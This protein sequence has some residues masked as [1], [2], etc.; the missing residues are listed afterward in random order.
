YSIGNGLVGDLN[1]TGPG[2]EPGYYQNDFFMLAPDI[3][4]PY[5]SGWAVPVNKNNQTNTYPLTAGNYYV[6]GDFV[7]S[8]NE[9]MN[10]SGNVTLYVTGNFN[11][12]SQ[13]SCFINILPGAALTL[14]VG[15]TDVSNPVSTQMTQVNTS[16]NAFSFRYFGLTS[17]TGLTWN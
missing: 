16:G 9:T 14:Y 6:K 17:N 3:V 7:M 5:T 13:N 1:W 10:V 15:T 8:Q 2:I 12:K 4:A 11:M